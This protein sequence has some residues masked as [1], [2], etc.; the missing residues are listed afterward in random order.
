MKQ[1]KFDL[2]LKRPDIEVN[3]PGGVPCWQRPEVSPV[4]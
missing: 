3:K 2:G 1:T 4:L